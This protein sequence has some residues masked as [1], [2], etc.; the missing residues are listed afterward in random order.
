MDLVS[1]IIRTKN[2]E[3][4][5][6]SCLNALYTQSYKNFEVVVVDNQSSDSTLNRIK[7]FPVKLIK[8]KKFIP[9]K[10]INQGIRA[11]K[12]K[13]IVCLSGHC[14]PKD[15]SWL[16]N[17][18]KNLKDKSVAGVYGRQEP[19]SYSSDL[20]KRDLINLFGLDKKIQIKDSFFHNAN[21]A[22]RREIWKKFPFNEKL[23][24]IEDR[25]WGNK[26][27]KAG[28]KIVY[29]P[30]ASVFHWHGVHHDM[31]TDR[32]KKIVKILENLDKYKKKPKSNKL[33][34]AF[35]P[36][37]GKT[38][39]IDNK[40][41]LTYTV[42]VLKKS[43][44]ISKIF[45]ITDSK[46]TANVAKKLGAEVPFLRPKFLSES[47]ISV[48]DVI[49]YTLEKIQD[50]YKRP[51]YVGIFEEIYPFRNPKM[52]N[53]MISQIFSYNYDSIISAKYEPRGIF[54]NS[55]NKIE[56][57]FDRFMPSKLKSSKL[58]IS[59]LGFG[60]IVKT[61][62]IKTGGVIGNNVGF[63]EVN[64]SF[65]HIPIKSRYDLNLFKSIIKNIKMIK[66]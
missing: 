2:E 56:M 40:H 42:E 66:N 35:I 7:D 33:I 16:S 29:E 63:F 24:N 39:K 8:I 34:Y 4:W 22:F 49:Q 1:I 31:N 46:Y 11:S 65:S 27:I 41:L 20:D 25:D 60:A 17:L 19:L 26:V 45:V 51:D 3:R 57:F 38:Y 59:L 5:I 28:Y 61:E 36:I 58:H 14:I 6:F 62:L 23:S 44:K 52:I 21:S 48:V 30:L 13:I 43:K 64:N 47:H 10:A 54:I 55:N 15:K 9:G 53:G 32:A 50:L 37:K 12:G 18:I